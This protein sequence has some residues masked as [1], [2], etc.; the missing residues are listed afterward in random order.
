MIGI[1]LAAMDSDDERKDFTELYEK[2]NQDVFRVSYK[3][4]QDVGSAEDAAQNVW[5]WAAKNYVRLKE[6]P[7]GDIQAYLVTAGKHTSYNLLRKERRTV[8]MD[9]I[10]P[11]QPADIRFLSEDED[12]EIYRMITDILLGMPDKYV[13]VLEMKLILEMRAREIAK[14]LGLK[15]STVETRIFRGK[16]ILADRLRKEMDQ[17]DA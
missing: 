13:E 11:V 15:Q 3:I 6:I 17:D 7:T 14:E 5:L 1:C 16:K 4:L 12:R 2:Y 8:L 9:D 10:V